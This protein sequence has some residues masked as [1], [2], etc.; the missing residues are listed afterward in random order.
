MTTAITLRLHH[1][2]L[3]NSPILIA[4]LRDAT[5]GPAYKQDKAGPPYVPV[6]GYVD[7]VFTS[8]VALSYSGG[9]IRQFLD[10]GE[11]TDEF[12]FDTP[13]LDGIESS[14]GE[15][16]VTI[17]GIDLKD[18]G[19]TDFTGTLPGDGTKTF[20]PTLMVFHCT[21][22]AAPLNGDAQVKVGLSLGGTE[23]LP[24]TTLTSINAVD[25]GFVVALTGHFDP[26]P[27]NSTIH[28]QVSS[29]DT[30]AGTGTVQA[31]LEG[32]AF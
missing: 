29:A 2:G 21:A 23:I 3:R 28:V 4:D 32:R 22:A 17:S 9:N 13:F 10:D 30:G 12:I 31:K 19:A 8:D 15:P 18:G 14:E 27:D 5:D 26:I 20:I 1:G 16:D 6:G 25:E 24:A 7:Y 11:V